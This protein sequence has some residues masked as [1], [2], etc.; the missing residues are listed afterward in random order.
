MYLCLL[1][2]YSLIHCRMLYYTLLHPTTV[3]YSPV[4]YRPVHYRPVAYR[5]EQYLPRC[6]QPS[7]PEG[8]SQIMTLGNNSYNFEAFYPTSSD[9]HYFLQK[10]AFLKMRNSLQVWKIN[11]RME[12]L[13]GKF[14]P[15]I[16]THWNFPKCQ[17]VH[18]II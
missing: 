8:N 3:H 13:T 1:L 17:L 9:E 2:P 12:D 5:T 16:L 10:K 4:P 18:I 15:E 6:Y 14:I 11:Y 7:A